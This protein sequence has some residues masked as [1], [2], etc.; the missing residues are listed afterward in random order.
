MTDNQ[1][2]SLFKAYSAGANVMR[3]TLLDAFA[4]AGILES[5]PRAASFFKKLKQFDNELTKEQF[6]ALQAC[7]PALF[8][9]VL[10][11][12]LALAQFPNFCGELA[13]IFEQVVAVKDGKLA[14]Y[15]PQLERVDP[16][17]FAMSLCSIDGQQY[18]LGDFDDFFC[19][20]SC[21]KP[22]TY[23]LALEENGED[24]VHRF[25]G[26]EPSGKTF[27][28]LT[29][30]SRGKPH[31]PMINAGAI[32]SG[33]LIRK[34]VS[35]ADRF[36]YVMGIWKELSGNQKVGFDNAVYLSER[37]TGDRNF[38]LGY[39][40]REKNA[41][42]PG[43]E[44]LDILDFY[45][46]CCSIEV[47]SKAMSVIAATLANGG[48]CPLTGAQVFRPDHVKNC[49]S[50]MSSCGMYDF[51]GEFAFS[52]GIPGKSGVSGAIMLVVPNLLGMVLWSPRLDEIGNSVRGI[53]F[54]KRLSS[55]FKLHAFDSMVGLKDER[56]D[57]RRNPYESKFGAVVAFC[58]ASMEGDIMEMRRIVANGLDPNTKDYNKRTALHL[59][60][61]AGRLSVVQ[62]LL[63]IGVEVNPVDDWG[64]TPLD[65]AHR[66]KH[67]SAASLLAEHGGVQRQQ[68]HAENK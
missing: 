64:N 5:D 31:N 47:S 19:V 25:V 12:Q 27:N 20:Q 35:A 45:F 6:K 40:M 17:K 58:A 22:I 29:L 37:Q 9:K 38:A 51:S 36:D 44:L 2:G 42:P 60:A 57:P 55:R 50:L 16:E 28:E 39:F 8:D 15:I 23:L 49:L 33:S 46:Q 59:A 54:C 4:E 67:S 21:S 53:E 18:S 43:V 10:T 34:G 26:T 7:S 3:R 14:N 62:Y 1:L 30:N 63:E 65:D 48:T 32:M 66:H 52:V 56:V 61:S 24:I 41:F 68:L 13:D 11:G